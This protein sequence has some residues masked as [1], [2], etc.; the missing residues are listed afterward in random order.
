M[1]YCLR[2]HLKGLLRLK[3]LEYLT[4]GLNISD[5]TSHSGISKTGEV[6]SGSKGNYDGRAPS[7]AD[8]F[9]PARQPHIPVMANEVLEILNPRN[10]QTIIDMTYGAG[11]HS[12]KILDH[13]ADLKLVAVDR[14]P[15]AHKMSC[16]MAQERKGQSTVIPVLAR[17]SELANHLAENSI[18][19]GSVDN[20]LFDLG[21]S[22]MQFDVSER[23]FSLSQD[24]PLDMRMD[25]AR[26]QDQPTAAD[27]INTLDADELHLV[28][29]RYGEERLSRS[30]AQA[31]VDARY[32]FGSISRTRQLA[33]IVDMVFEGNY[34]QDKLQRHAHPATRTFQALRIFVNNELNELHNGLELA[35]HYLRPGGCC[36]VI[37]F[38]SLED[39]VVKRH[40]HGIE[41]DNMINM[42]IGQHYR[43]S[44][45]TQS[46]NKIDQLLAKKWRPLSKKVLAPTEEE[47]KAN[48]R[49]RSAK[50]RA[51]IKV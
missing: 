10:G 32:A 24:G 34:K 37:S 39:R 36:V 50:L 18:E 3:G 40:F 35:S 28:L 44:I 17:F 4:K 1:S 20:I 15:V 2:K 25:G 16:L 45:I 42:S 51:A 31:I 46:K 33:D 8:Q 23:G 12:N 48:P 49:A 19:K 27:V 7:T 30:I 9:S 43:N 22:S 14:D 38:H 26:F 41:M 11:G 47:V 29:R 6:L 5:V 21:A 13:A